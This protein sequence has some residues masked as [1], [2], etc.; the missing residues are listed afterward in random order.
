V[1]GK[2]AGAP[3]GESWLADTH[4]GVW[5][6]SA[7]QYLGA[8]YPDYGASDC[9]AGGR[10]SRAAQSR[11]MYPSSRHLLTLEALWIVAVVLHGLE[12]ESVNGFSS[13]RVIHGHLIAI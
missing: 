8:H 13:L 12:N 3:G 9:N 11:A 5:P 6:A 7:A 4:T 2:P 1:E 10:S